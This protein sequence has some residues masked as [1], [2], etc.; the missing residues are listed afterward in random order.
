EGGWNAPCGMKM[1]AGSACWHC[2][3][4]GRHWPLEQNWPAGQLTLAHAVGW[5]TGLF[6]LHVPSGMQTP[7]PQSESFVQPGRELAT[8]QELSV[9]GSHGGSCFLSTHATKK[10]NIRKRTFPHPI[11]HLP[12]AER[13]VVI[14]R[15]VGKQDRREE[16]TWTLT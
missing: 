15:P 9:S 12:K 14:A 10:T 4:S 8:L 13:R 2:A 6:A 5:S 1:Q 16:N 7:S 11:P 3:F